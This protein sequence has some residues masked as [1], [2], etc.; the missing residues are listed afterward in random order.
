MNSYLLLLRGMTAATKDVLGRWQRGR[1]YAAC[2][3]FAVAGFLFGAK[4]GR[5]PV[6]GADLALTMGL[7]AI[8]HQK[9]G[10]SFH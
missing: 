10:Y 1:P 2:R 3:A 4:F 6:P 5:A 9:L 8:L 7:G